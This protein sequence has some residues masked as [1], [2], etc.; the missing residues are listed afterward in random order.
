MSQHIDRVF[1][2]STPQKFLLPVAVLAGVFIYFLSFLQ[3]IFQTA[4]EN[5]VWGV[6]FKPLKLLRYLKNNNSRRMK[7]KRIHVLI[8]MNEH[9]LID[10]VNMM[11]LFTLLHLSP[12]VKVSHCLSGG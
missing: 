10:K 3:H 12:S 9:P 11:W 2:T 5:Y 6:F 8:E 1:F 7:L 4:S